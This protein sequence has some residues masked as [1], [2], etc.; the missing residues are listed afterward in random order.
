MERVAERVGIS[1]SPVLLEPSFNGRPIRANSS[2]RVL[3][4]GILRE[5]TTAYRDALTPETIATVEELA[6][7][8]Y[9]RLGRRNRVG[10]HR[11]GSHDTAEM[12]AQRVRPRAVLGPPRRPA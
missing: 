3:Q 5:R 8:L 6:G 4:Y 2:N 10:P 11:I 12:C 1:M 9:E 7:D